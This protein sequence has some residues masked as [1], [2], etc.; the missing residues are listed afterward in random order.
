MD[1]LTSREHQI[2]S[3]VCKGCT[4][5]E[6]AKLL[7]VSLATVKTHLLRVFSKT[8]VNNR[9]ALAHYMSLRVM[10]RQPAELRTE[11]RPRR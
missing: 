2:A 7:G 10:S 1:E 9:A 4:N 6:I 8:N 5:A 3:L 11:S